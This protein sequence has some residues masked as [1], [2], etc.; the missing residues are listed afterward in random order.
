[1]DLHPTA[2]YRHMAQEKHQM[3]DLNRR[4]QSYLGRVKLLEEENTM[5]SQEIQAQRHGHHGASVREK[6]LKE[7]LH[8]ARAEL[9]KV[10]RE[11][12][13][14]EMEVCKLSEEIQMVERH[15]QK[16]A[17][18]QAEI[19][20]KMEV[21]RKELEEEHGAQRWLRER[22]KQ[23]EEEMD[24]RVRNHEADV[25]HLETMLSHSI[26]PRTTPNLD[27]LQLEQELSQQASRA[28][29][30]TAEAYQAQLD[31]LEES[32]RET[33]ARLGQAEHHKNEYQAHLRA[34]ERDRIS[35]GDVRR[36]LEETAEQQREEHRQH[37]NTLQEH[38]E[39]LEKEKEHLGQQLDRLVQENRGLLQQKMSLGLEV[40][41]YRAL[42]DGESLRRDDVS[43]LKDSRNIT[44]KDMP[45]KPS[46]GNYQ[47]PGRC[48]TLASVR[49]APITSTTPLRSKPVNISQAR[50]GE[51]TATMVAKQESPY[52]K[53][54]YDG[55][56]EK[57]R[58]QEVDEKVTYAEPLSS[59]VGDE[60]EQ[61]PAERAEEEY[62][63]KS[64]DKASFG[65]QVQSGSPKSEGLES[66]I[67]EEKN[68]ISHC[69][70]STQEPKSE[71]LGMTAKTFSSSAR[72]NPEQQP[73]FPVEEKAANGFQLQPGV[74]PLTTEI[75]EYQSSAQE[76]TSDLLVMTEKTFS[77]TAGSDQKQ[78]PCVLEEKATVAFEIQS[79]AP[80][81]TEEIH[82]QPSGTQELDIVGITEET[83]SSSA[84]YKQ[85]LPP[86]VPVAEETAVGFQLQS[87]AQL[88]P[89]EITPHHSST[90]KSKTE[91]LTMTEEIFSSAARAAVE[92]C[93]V[94]DE[95]EQTSSSGTEALLE[96]TLE[97]R[98]SSPSSENEFNPIDVSE[99]KQEISYSTLG[100]TATEAVDMLY[101][102]GEEMDTWDSVIE[103]KIHVESSEP[104]PEAES[105]FAK[106]EEDI[107]TRRSELSRGEMKK[108][109]DEMWLQREESSQHS[110][111]KGLNEED[112]DSQN[113]SV[114]WRTELESDSY[115]QENTLADVRPLIRYTSDETDANT[116]ASHVDES[117]SS[118]GEQDGQTGEVG[119]PAWSESKAKNFG[120][121][122]D[123]C[124]EV[125]EEVVENDKKYSQEASGLEKSTLKISEGH[126]DEEVPAAVDDVELE[127]D[128]LVEQ[129]LE[130]LSIDSYACHFAEEVANE[131]QA[132]LPEDEEEA[133]R[134]VILKQEVITDIQVTHNLDFRDSMQPQRLQEVQEE[135]V[136]DGMMTKEQ[137]AI[138]ESDVQVESNLD[139]RD[140]VQPQTLEEVEVVEVQDRMMKMR[141]ELIK[142]TELKIECNQVLRD[143]AQPQVDSP[144]DDAKGK[145]EER[146]VQDHIMTTEQEVIME[147]DT[148]V[149]CNQDIRNLVSPQVDTM[150]HEKK[151]QDHIMTTEQEVIMEFDTQVECNQDIRNL[152]SPQVDTMDHEKKVQDEMMTME[153]EEAGIGL[154]P[155]GM[156]SDVQVE[157]DQDRQDSI[158]P[159]VDTPDDDEEKGMEEKE[160]QDELT[161]KEQETI[162]ES[163]VQVES[164]LDLKDSVQPQ[165]LEEVEQ[166]EVQDG[167]MKMGEEFI[168][169][170][171]LK[172]ECDQV[173]GDSV[174]TQLDSA[175]EDAKEKVEESEVQER[176]I[177]MEQEVTIESAVQ[178]EPNQDI[179]SLVP[180]QMDTM[181]DEEKVQDEIMRIEHEEAGKGKLPFCMDSD[182][183]VED[184]LDLEDS[185]PPQLHTPDDEKK[186]LEEKEVQHGTLGQEEERKVPLFS[187]T[188]S[189]VL[190]ES[191]L[192]SAPYQSESPGDEEK[193]Q[194]EITTM[195]QEEAEQLNSPSYMDPDVQV[196]GNLNISDF[197]PPQV[198]SPDDQVKEVQDEIL[199][200]EEAQKVY[201]LSCM[202]SEVQVEDNLNLVQPQLD[203]PHDG[204]KVQ[205]E[206]MT[207]E[208]EVSKESAVQVEHNQDIMSFVP[209]QIDTVDDKEKVENEIMS[210]EL[211]EAD[212]GKL[213]S[214]MDPDV[215]IDDDLDPEDSIPPQMDTPD[216]D[217]K[218]G[219]EEKEVQ[220]EM[221]GQKETQEVPLLSCTESDVQVEHNLNLVQPQLDSPDDE[222]KVQ[223]EIMPT[224]Q[225]EADKVSS[226]SYMDP[227]FQV[228]GNLDLSDFIPP[229]VDSPD[230]HVKEVQEEILKQEEAQKVYL[231]SCMESEVRVER[232]LNLV[233]PQLDSPDDGE[234]VQDKIMTTEQEEANKLNVPSCV[235]PDTQVEDDLD[236]REFVQPLL[237]S[238]D[239]YL[240]EVQDITLNQQDAVKVNLPV[241]GY[242]QDEDMLR[243]DIQDSL[244]APEKRKDEFESNVS[245]V[246]HADETYSEFL[247]GLDF[248]EEAEEELLEK[249][250]R[251]SQNQKGL[252]Q[253]YTYSVGEDDAS[254]L[255]EKWNILENTSEDVDIRHP[256]DEAESHVSHLRDEVGDG[257]LAA[258][259]GEKP[260]EISLKTAPE[261]AVIFA[262]KDSLSEFLKTND[263]ENQNLWAALPADK[264]NVP[265]NVSE[266][267][268]IRHPKN[269]EECG[270]SHG[271]EEAG[272]GESAPKFD[273]KHVAISP[274]TATEESIFAVKDS[275]TEFRKTNVKDKRDLWVSSMEEAAAYGSDDIPKVM[276]GIHDVE[277]GSELDWGKAVNGSSARD[278]A[279][280]K[281]EHVTGVSVHSEESEVEGECWS[282]G[283]E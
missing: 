108:Q 163:D 218:K 217:E 5:L 176:I 208:Q 254:I 128:Q 36:Q 134:K 53:I 116:Q 157:D 193:V 34:L 274:E 41:T 224:E 81:R 281:E 282:S 135:D 283:D 122:E 237:D 23:L 118:D 93:T 279:G 160:V 121:M 73:T 260:V 196:E 78:S 158:L 161:A 177:T 216:D 16:E 273:E 266:D 221:L 57:F 212:K 20:A 191:N 143:S 84:V 44:L 63:G 22:I 45:V 184:D 226:P 43:L 228:E 232:S 189:D 88:L 76:P 9:D 104:K 8:R 187:C 17:L 75:T 173:H 144:N 4:L 239:D 264:W 30:E 199:K 72:W 211:T 24:H 186:G 165:T 79:E 181:E 261:E 126:L 206:I 27:L 114:S 148:Q 90:H 223:D 233:Q 229:Q 89:K 50:G 71:L 278:R 98:T 80:P 220:H 244:E 111:D 86:C 59:P 132:V 243:Q 91:L 65:F 35:E 190:V 179:R 97:S 147:F 125:D 138:P 100:T 150:D 18:A 139:L 133:Q 255:A 140:S 215:Q 120:T 49:R 167:M 252:L 280:K 198:D 52:P 117:E 182:V 102:D 105:Q 272:D 29:H 171:E 152:V 240:E 276:S 136:H 188:E 170:T 210:I 169:E 85:E 42:L 95:Q 124:E 262:M 225:E 110:D 149:E 222:E 6:S 70:S 39:C 235:D 203:T 129:E 7:D 251:E 256:K 238:P 109:D 241:S 227:D 68:K 263:R 83:I 32:L 33:A 168:K 271:D 247:R 192:D 207:T 77:S 258:T 166:V 25:A 46:R 96:P 2:H 28:W 268:N 119:E 213:P 234:K 214:C 60:H 113:I 130:N 69:Q 58:A 178:V 19:K 277:F 174:Q 154:L 257:E 195:E 146:E 202:E 11:R 103:K 250:Q 3:L 64:E 1:M 48:N 201:L 249:P 51:E 137:D 101:P 230:D 92:P 15:C 112:E 55:A 205:D 99:I 246:T 145:V 131:S 115:A 172:V 40:V 185:I 13:Y 245:M 236:L 159:Q 56:V 74:L 54:L 127:T 183:Q 200:Q 94:E 180:P 151:V 242:L 194:V 142:E 26:P 162:P 156:D 204:E 37:I 61:H 87:G 12:V 107:L 31:Q 155:S 231:Q 38:W 209:P 197:I 106:P 10:W 82:Q 67:I 219:I 66:R 265:E 47:L 62:G 253:E 123:L 248:L 164:K 269:E 14:T 141:E 175:I 270:L 153:Y 275:L 21:S 259:F 267:V